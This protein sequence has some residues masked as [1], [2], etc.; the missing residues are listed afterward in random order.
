[1]PM[2]QQG[3]GKNT[4]NLACNSQQASEH[5]T[6]TSK[7]ETVST[8]THQEEQTA[9]DTAKTLEQGQEE[10]KSVSSGV[11]DRDAA[12]GSVHS[13]EVTDHPAQ[14]CQH[15]DG[16][17]SG[18]EGQENS[19]ADLDRSRDSRWSRA[20]VDTS[21]RR[22]RECPA[23]L[24]IGNTAEQLKAEECSGDRN[25]SNTGFPA[26]ADS[27]TPTSSCQQPSPDPTPSSSL[28]PSQK[29][30]IRVTDSFHGDQTSVWDS[31]SSVVQDCET[32]ERLR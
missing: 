23:K 4:H 15:G 30:R 9:S 19:H 1:M 7:A 18:A 25:N 16:L 11:H 31:S 17:K 2:I 6:H 28:I 12:T 32:G 8:Q 27:S 3:P 21:D 22:E 29:G 20:G 10:Q 24:D 5:R 14:D 26:A 13:D